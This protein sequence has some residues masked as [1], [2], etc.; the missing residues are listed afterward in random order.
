[1]KIRPLLIVLSFVVLLMIG[2]T[3]GRSIVAFALT[4]VNLSVGGTPA[5]TTDSSVAVNLTGAQPS[6]G[7]VL[8][9]QLIVTDDAGNRSAPATVAV[10][11]HGTPTAT[12]S[13]PAT[14]AAGAPITLVGSGS[15]PGGRITNYTWQLVSV[16]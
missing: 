16:R 15:E 6:P 12:I 14:V 1:M 7:S 2:L 5:T 4:S 13:G 9:F 8:T 10:T 3:A 11:V